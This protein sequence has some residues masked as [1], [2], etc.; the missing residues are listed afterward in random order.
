MTPPVSYFN[1]RDMTLVALGINCLQPLPVDEFETSFSLG[2]NGADY[3]SPEMAYGL[4]DPALLRTYL[5]TMNRLLRAKGKAEMPLQYIV[6][7]ANQLRAMVDLCHLYGIAVVL[8]VVYNHAGGFEGDDESLYFWDRQAQGDNNN[9]LYFTNQDWAGGLAFA[10][11]K[12]PVRQFLIDNAAYYANEFHVDGF[13]YDEISV[14]VAKNASTGWSFCQDLTG[15]NRF[16]KA[17]MLQNAEYWPVNPAVVEPSAEQG[18]GFDV[19]QHDGFRDSLRIVI[20]QAAVGRDAAVDLD[21]VAVQIYPPGF[22]HAWQAVTCVENHDLVKAGEQQRI[23]ALADGS[24]HR[25]WFAC[26]R[27]H[28]ASGLLLTAPGIPM[29]FM[30]QEFLEDKQWSDDPQSGHLI[31]WDGLVLNQ[32]PMVDFLRFT[33]DLLRLRWRQPALRGQQLNVFHVHNQNRLIAFHRWIEGAGHDV[34]VVARLNESTFPDYRIGFPS[35]GRWLEVFNSDVYQNWV[36]PWVA[37]N[38][39]AVEATDE[40]LHGFAASCSVVVP[41]NSIVVF[42]RDSGV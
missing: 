41:A 35:A 7:A 9:S 39:G 29:L 12:Q 30:G 5:E 38:G 34:V 26:S 2:Y 42:A 10:L 1:L 11:W 36:N 40:P 31:Y 16:R 21:R 33:Q 22:P 17:R 28:V 4:Y 3:F 18:A 37:G 19:T 20:A 24:D 27:A 8:D 6:G 14:L 13:R 23:A 25:S 32:K 15:T